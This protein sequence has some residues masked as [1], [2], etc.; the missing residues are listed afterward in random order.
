MFSLKPLEM[1]TMSQQGGKENLLDKKPRYFLFV[2][3]PGAH[4]LCWARDHCSTFI[5]V[6]PVDI[7]MSSGLVPAVLV[8]HFSIVLLAIKLAKP[9]CE[10]PLFNIF[11]HDTTG[12]FHYIRT[13]FQLCFRGKKR[14]SWQDTKIFSSCVCDDRTKLAK[15]W[16]FAERDTIVQ[17]F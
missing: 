17:Y 4:D 13:Y 3:K 15:T 11:K 9:K 1:F 14:S 12:Y 6:K 5:S 7:L 2:V 16:S 8:A 10:I